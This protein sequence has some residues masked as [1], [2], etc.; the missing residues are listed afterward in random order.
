[1]V[2]VQIDAYGLCVIVHMMLHGSYMAVE[3]KESLDGSYTYKP[4]SVLKRYLVRLFGIF[5]FSIDHL[6]K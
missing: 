4:K 5:H 3:K 2:S 6:L 1:M